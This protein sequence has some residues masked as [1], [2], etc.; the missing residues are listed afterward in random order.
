MAG[1]AVSP[2]GA[3][4]VDPLAIE[5]VLVEGILRRFLLEEVTKVGFQ[6]V[7]VGV[8]G[9]VDSAL[10]LWLAARALGPAQ[11]LAVLLPYRESDPQSLADAMA[12]V[13]QVGV[14]A[15]TIDIS[16]QVDAYF[17]AVPT[18]DRRRRGNKLARERMAVL[19]DCSLAESALVVGTSNKTELLLGYGTVFGDLAHALNPLG[20]LYKTQVYQLARHARLPAAVLAKPA[21]A[22]HWPGQSDEDDLGFTYAVADRLLYHLVDERRTEE[23]CRGLGFDAELVRGV[24]ER[25]RQSQFKRRLPLIAKLSQRTIGRDF[26]YPRDWGR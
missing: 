10:A 14:H 8:S 2:V 1:E 6:R 11:V 4:D 5:P 25:I 22:D 16:P 3:E 26:R 15:R 19:H 13:A 9:G 21:S 20:D 12:V 23:E 17:A 7:V 18:G 24:R